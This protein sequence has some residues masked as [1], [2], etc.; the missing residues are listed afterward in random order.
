MSSAAAHVF[1]KLSFNISRNA[2]QVEKSNMLR[3][4]K[5]NHHLET[6]IK[7]DIEKPTRRRRVHT[8]RV[9]SSGSHLREVTFNLISI[10]ELVSFAR[11]TKCAVR[12]AFHPKLF[13][14]DKQK[15]PADNRSLV[16]AVF[17]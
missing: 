17:Y 8:H 16:S 3:P 4:R 15:L 11:R 9:E 2:G 12:D 13:V 7:R 1:T 14:A 6:A 5:A 10:R